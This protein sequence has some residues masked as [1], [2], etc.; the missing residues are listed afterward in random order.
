MGFKLDSTGRAGLAVALAIGFL[1]VW[2]YFPAGFVA[3]TSSYWSTEVDDVTQYFAGFNAFFKAP[4]SYPLLAFDSIN[5]PQGTRVTFVD[6]IPLYALL[7]KLFVPAS[8]AP[9]NP[10]GVWVALAF[11]GQAVC[12]WWILRELQIKSWLALLAL[13]VCLLTFPALTTRLG[14]I[15]LMSHWIILCALALYIRCRRTSEP[16]RWGWSL[17]LVAAFYI[18]IYLFVMASAIYVVSCLCNTDKFKPAQIVRALIPFLIIGVS[19][20]LTIFPMERVEVAPE[21]GFGIYSMNL[22]S[23]FHGGNYFKFPDPE[24]PGQYEGFN[25]LGLGVLLAFAVALV[26]NSKAAVSRFSQHRAL[27][28]L[29]VLFTVYALSNLVYYGT[30]LVVT[31]NYPLFMDRITSQFRASGRFFWPVGYCVVIFTFA[32]LHRKLSPWVFAACMII[33]V[34]LQVSDLSDRRHQLYATAK[35]PAA[36]VLTQAAWDQQFT[37]DIKYLYFFPKFRCGRSDLVLNTLMPTMRYAAVHDLKINTGYVA[38]VNSVCGVEGAKSE[39][40]ASAPNQSLY[41]F[42]KGDFP[43]VEQVKALFPANQQPTCTEVDFAHICRITSSG[44]ETQ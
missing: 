41:V 33:L 42:V 23:P 31:I 5:Y 22:L 6:A 30:H 13:V 2:R 34:P 28:W 15:S 27:T 35:R 21:T 29:M 7:L 16:Q 11:I 43:Q 37:G 3:G 39:I 40:A 17:L 14:H 38:R 1:F 10:F 8:F 25:Y 12:A 32:T 9:F 19:L 44:R 20:F 24:M 18:N 4:F 36:P 26:L